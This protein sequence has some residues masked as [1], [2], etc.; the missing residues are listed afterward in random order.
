MSQFT[1][2][3][4]VTGQEFLVKGP[5]GLTESQAAEI[6]AQQK[7]KG[8]LVNLKPGDILS[9]AKQAAAGLGSAIAQVQQA[10]AGIA[11]SATGALGGALR[12]AQGTVAGITGAVSGAVNSGLQSATTLSTGLSGALGSAKSLA[13]QTLS[14]ITGATRGLAITNGINVANFAKQSTALIPI[15]NL[16]VTNITATMAQASR[17]V[18]QAPTTISNSLGVG[19]FGLD[20]KQLELAGMVKPGTAAKYLAS[21]A[22]DLTS[23]L[24]SPTVWTGKAGIKDA[25]SL[26]RSVPSQDKIQQTLMNTGLNQ[27]QALGIPINS[28]DPNKLAGTA[29]NAAKSAK[30][31]LAWAAGTATSAVKTAFNSVARAAEFAVGFG[32][33]KIT[34]AMSGVTVPVPANFTVDRK[35]LNAA[36]TR[37]VGNKKI[38]A[39]NYEEPIV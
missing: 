31:T 27:V 3:D 19:K 20:C 10:A 26:L 4:P 29:L 7:D 35:T 5:G 30:D 13:D 15:K 21:G 37:I 34:S 24:N 23:V 12:T 1:F 14:G 36:V 25:A 8:S 22:N 2:V 16:S 28:L 6:F 32:S 38:P 39:V 9:A 17:L 18:G 11:G 33:S